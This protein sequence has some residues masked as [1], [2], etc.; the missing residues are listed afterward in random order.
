M[1]HF[2]PRTPLRSWVQYIALLNVSIL[3]TPQ[4]L[5]KY[6]RLYRQKRKWIYKTSSLSSSAHQTQFPHPAYEM[7]RL[8]YLCMYV[9]ISTYMLILSFKSVSQSKYL[10]RS[11]ILA[12]PPCH[13]ESMLKT[14][15]LR[16]YVMCKISPTTQNILKELFCCSSGCAMAADGFCFHLHFQH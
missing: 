3:T 1:V 9:Y 14:N 6:V 2:S 15:I 12:Y 8:T 4:K 13:F 11:F 7:Q 10:S 16:R 5:D